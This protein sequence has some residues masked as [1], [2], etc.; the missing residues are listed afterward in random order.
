MKMKRSRGKKSPAKAAVDK[1]KAKKR[2]RDSRLDKTPERRKQR[3]Y[4]EAESNRKRR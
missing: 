1:E 2:M 3:S 4:A